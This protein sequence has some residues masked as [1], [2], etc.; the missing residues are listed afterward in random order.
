MNNSNVT[1]LP[2]E[3]K[4]AVEKERRG[5]LI[6]AT[7][8]VRN[9]INRSRQLVNNQNISKSEAGRDTVSGEAI[10]KKCNVYLPAGY[11]KNRKDKK[12]DVLYL[13]HGVGGNSYEWLSDNGKTDNQF[14]ICNMLDNLIAKGDINPLIVVFPEGR[15]SSDWQDRSFNANGTNMLGFYYFDYEMRWDLIPFIESE[16]NTNANI[17]D[18][19]QNGISYNR[20]HRAI[21]GLSIGGMQ[22]LN[23]AIGG[24][25]CDSS[26]ITGKKSE[27]NNG[28]SATVKAP[29]ML[30]LFAY[31]GGFSNAPT[32]SDGKVLGGSIAKSGQTLKVLYL[33]CGDADSIAYRDGY[34]RAVDGLSNTAGTNLKDDYRI[35]VKG[36][37]HDFNVWNNGA[38]NFL[39]LSFE[40]VK[41]HSVPYKISTTINGRNW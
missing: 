2:Y 19:T 31:A 5:T 27:W 32:S 12:Y 9:Y 34:L 14:N 11:D 37:A 10:R 6:E 7:Y 17:M 21:A 29:G 13:L 24:Y 8:N 39:R 41:P 40:N 30:D 36:G 26:T 25:R 15:S 20:L 3:Y 22:T 28:L 16:F 1:M 33:T 18:K 4:K 35:L 38:F 23:M